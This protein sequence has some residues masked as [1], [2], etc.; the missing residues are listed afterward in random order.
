LNIILFAFEEL[1]DSAEYYEVRAERLGESFL[2]EVARA[3]ADVL[4]HRNG[5]HIFF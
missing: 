3:V 2:D 4:N 5:G 1:I